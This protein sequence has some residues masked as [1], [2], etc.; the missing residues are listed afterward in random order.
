MQ[1]G[2]YTHLHMFSQFV[3]TRNHECLDCKS[4]YIGHMQRDAVGVQMHSAP[5]YELAVTLYCYYVHDRDSSRTCVLICQACPGY[6]ATSQYTHCE[7]RTI[8]IRMYRGRRRRNAG[9]TP[10]PQLV[11]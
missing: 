5:V 3:I 1:S 9:F 11:S 10:L 4:L 6:N 7:Q 2:M 8:M